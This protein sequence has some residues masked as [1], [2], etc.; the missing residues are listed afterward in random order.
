MRDL[1]RV[2]ASGL[3]ISIVLLTHAVSQ[4]ALTGV[5]TD[6]DG[7]LVSNVTVELT[8]ERTAKVERSLYTEDEV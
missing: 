8:N 1:P 7:A 2:L 6:P 5:I 3:L 4:S